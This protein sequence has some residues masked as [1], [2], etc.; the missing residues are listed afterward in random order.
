MGYSSI[1]NYTVFYKYCPNT[2]VTLLI[3]VKAARIHGSLIQREK[4]YET[5][6]DYHLLKSKPSDL[7]ETDMS[8]LQGNSF[9]IRPQF[10]PVVRPV[11]FF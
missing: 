10:R 1:Q 2:T 9:S 4:E 5:P 3:K 8:H 11:F 7:I 6:K